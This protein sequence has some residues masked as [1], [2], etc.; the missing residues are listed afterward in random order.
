MRR[1][2]PPCKTRGMARASRRPGDHRRCDRG[3]RRRDRAGRDRAR[4][5]ARPRARRCSPCWTRRTRSSGSRC[6]GSRST[7]WCCSASAAA[8]SSRG[9]VRPLLIAAL[10]GALLRRPRA[11]G[12]AQG[13]AADRR[14]RRGGRR[15]GAAGPRARPLGAGRRRR[16]A[17]AA[18]AR[19]RHRDADH[20]GRGQRAA[21][22]A[23]ADPARADAVGGPRLAQRRVH[24][25]RADRRGRARRRCSPRPTTG[26][27]GPRSGPAWSR[28]SRATPPGT[29]RSPGST[30]R[31]TS[32]SCS[33][34]WSRRGWRAWLQ[35]LG[36]GVASRRG[37]AGESGGYTCAGFARICR[38]RT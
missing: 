24:G 14:G 32:R 26:W 17:R 34:W 27:S 19:L 11:P 6:S 31:A 35:A 9:E 5:R 18:G 13:V 22:R 10:P 23:V 25:A 1:F 16:P 20:L 4:L 8:R 37:P 38:T 3:A 7:R 2:P 28:S 29:A 12:A 15:G 33:R 36:A 21:D 30:A